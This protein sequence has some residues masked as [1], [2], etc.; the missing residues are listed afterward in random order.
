MTAT[1][2][3]RSAADVIRRV[4]V[5]ASGCRLV[6]EATTH[7]IACLPRADLARRWAAQIRRVDGVV[8]DIGS[9]T[10]VAA[11]SGRRLPFRRRI[12]VSIALALALTGTPTKVVGANR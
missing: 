8:I 9:G 2:T 5:D 11:G 7:A 6:G 12:P 4:E 3:T 10:A 1:T